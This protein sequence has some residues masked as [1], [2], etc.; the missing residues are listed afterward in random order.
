[1]LWWQGWDGV[2][3][4]AMLCR[5]RAGGPLHHIATSGELV[6]WWSSGRA[7]ARWQPGVGL[8]WPSWVAFWA[9]SVGVRGPAVRE[10]VT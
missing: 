9:R 1:M 3:V 2:V 7:G 6:A 10:I 8:V 5:S 4:L